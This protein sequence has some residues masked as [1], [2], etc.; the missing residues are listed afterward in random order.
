MK[1]SNKADEFILRACQEKISYE[2]M[3]RMMKWPAKRIMYRVMLLRRQGLIGE[4]PR[5]RASGRV[6][7]RMCSICGRLSSRRG[8]TCGGEECLKELA[9]RKARL[10]Y[11]RM[12]PNYKT[13]IRKPRGHYKPRVKKVKPEKP[14][15]LCEICGRQLEKKKSKLCGSPECKAEMIRRY[16]RAAYQ[17]KKVKNE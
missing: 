9:R 1:W 8:A 17:R 15:K 13:G 12:H 5:C 7:D 4:K 11:A 2:D 16:G 14:V 10:Y 3:A 6:S